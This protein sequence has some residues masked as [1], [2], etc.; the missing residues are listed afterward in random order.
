MTSGNP[1]RLIL[2][3]AFPLLLGNLL[4]QTYNM[5]DAAIVGQ[6]L[7][8]D[9][10]AGVGATSSVQFLVLGFCIGTSVGFCIPV[11]QKFGAKD[12]TSMRKYIFNGILLTAAIAV[13]TTILTVLL[14]RNIILLLKT[15]DAIFGNAYI[16]LLIIF[17]GIP[18]TLLYNFCAGILR[19]IGD[20]RTPFIFLAISTILNVFLDLFCILVLKWGVAG[21]AIATIVSQGI[22]GILCAAVIIRKFT[23]LHFEENEKQVNAVISKNLL[24]MGI[25]MG[26]QYSITAIGSMVMQGANNSLGTI[27]VSGFTA[28][29]K[30]KQFAMCPFDALA[31]GVS[32]FCAQ[33]LGAGKR[34][35]IR[36]G[37]LQGIFIGI[38]YGLA[39]GLVLIFFGRPMSLL[40]IKPDKTKILDAS[41]Q[42]LRCMGYFY[43]AL[44]IL[45]VA[46]MV[47]Q[48]LGYAGRAMISGAV[49]MAARIFVSLVFVPMSGFT[50]ICWADQ[51]AW[52]TACCFI[53]PT[54]LLIVRNVTGK[55]PES[56][57]AENAGLQK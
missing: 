52:I 42:Y 13:F 32:T 36:T 44:G 35:R 23:F 16:Y 14:C 29:M 2:T 18:F 46:R 10:L 24:L 50:A 9:A 54:C 30:I 4:Q 5:A 55:L 22:S 7:G 19:A 56:V 11:A 12:Y 26:L 27:Y 47:T 48:A 6:F 15:P 37:M 53:L 1:V 41:A 34:D 57:P 43:W 25:P 31:T 45:N 51:T 40:F 49:E 38:G 20:S 39:I 21:A 8:S 28:G 17:I 3:F 33:N